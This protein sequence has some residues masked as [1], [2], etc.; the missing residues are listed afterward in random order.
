MTSCNVGLYFIPTGNHLLFTSAQ[1]N[2]PDIVHMCC[3]I[4]LYIIRTLFHM[5]Y[6]SDFTYLFH[7]IYT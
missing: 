4:H 5:I 1:S 7:M 3:S 2:V 6:M